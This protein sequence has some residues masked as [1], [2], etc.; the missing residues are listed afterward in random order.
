M[1]GRLTPR[2]LNRLRAAVVLPQHVGSEARRLV[3]GRIVT[4]MGSATNTVRTRSVLL[5]RTVGIIGAYQR[6]YADRIAVEEQPHE[7]IIGFR[8]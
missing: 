7:A 1:C 5:H 2:I 8:N 4:R 6:S 3:M